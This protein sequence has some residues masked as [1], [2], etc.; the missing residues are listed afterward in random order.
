MPPKIDNSDELLLQADAFFMPKSKQTGDDTLRESILEVIAK[1]GFF[2]SIASSAAMEKATD[3]WE[4]VAAEVQI[5]SKSRQR[6]LCK[7]YLEAHEGWIRSEAVRLQ[8]ASGKRGRAAKKPGLVVIKH[9]ISADYCKGQFTDIKK[10]YT[11]LATKHR[12]SRCATQFLH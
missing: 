4:A 1:Q 11:N 5:A 9:D 2:I 12:L 6:T 8:K 3:K 10:E 7:Q